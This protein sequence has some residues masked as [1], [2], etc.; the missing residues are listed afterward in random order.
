MNVEKDGASQ[1][2]SRLKK[3]EDKNF[4]DKNELKN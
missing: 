1:R 2:A 4:G 3:A